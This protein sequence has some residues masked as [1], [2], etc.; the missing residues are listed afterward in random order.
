MCLVVN[1]SIN[2]QNVFHA[3][4]P[5]N[6]LLSSSQGS[7]EHCI[8]GVQILSQLTGEMNQISEADA[9][10]SLTKHRKIASSYRDKQLFDIFRLSC[11]LLSNAQEN[12]KTMTLEGEGVSVNW[13]DVEIHSLTTKKS[14][15]LVIFIHPSLVV[16]TFQ[17]V[18]HVH[19]ESMPILVSVCTVLFET[20]SEVIK[21]FYQQQMLGL[22]RTMFVSIIV[23][24]WKWL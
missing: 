6:R 9:T 3:H 2:T 12:C 19:F 5:D 18:F 15:Q 14:S 21:S 16:C 23:G 22:K 1:Q 4:Q 24:F 20:K 8:I 7:V 10:R 13:K 17:R 11:S